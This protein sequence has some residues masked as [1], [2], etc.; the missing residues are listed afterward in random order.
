MAIKTKRKEKKIRYSRHHRALKKPSHRRV[1]C[2]D[3]MQCVAF[4]PCFYP[5][6][7]VQQLCTLLYQ[8]RFQ[9]AHSNKK[10]KKVFK[11]KEEKKAGREK[12]GTHLSFAGSSGRG[13][14]ASAA[15]AVSA[16]RRDAKPGCVL[17]LACII[18]VSSGSCTA[19]RY[20]FFRIAWAHY[21]ASVVAATVV[22][23]LYVKNCSFALMSSYCFV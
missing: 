7:Y 10:K 11:R 16:R 13:R 2:R 15:F 8:Y 5:Y 1:L 23:V 9:S 20:F 21:A 17:L 19:T 14:V 4:S 22:I 6:F 3:K 12:S 18:R